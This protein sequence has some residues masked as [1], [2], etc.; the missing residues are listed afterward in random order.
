MK[1]LLV[2]S[3]IGMITLS[4]FGTTFAE[5]KKTVK[6]T[7]WYYKCKSGGSGSFLCDGCDSGSALTIAVSICGG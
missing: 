7:T 1:K 4:S 2:L 6:L 3:V 5:E